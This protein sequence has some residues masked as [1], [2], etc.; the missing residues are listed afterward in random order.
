M[1]L[2]RVRIHPVKSFAGFDV[3][4]ATV[5][6]WGL[7]GDRRWAVVD[8]EGVSVTAR[9][10]NALLGL[11]ATP[12]AGDA[13]RLGEEHDT[14]GSLLVAAPRGAD[15][16][17]VGHSRQGT[18]LPAGDAADAWIS[19]RIGRPLRLVWQPDPTARTV[20]PD[21]GGRPGDSLTLADASPL[22]LASEASLRLLNELAAGDAAERG[23]A[24]PAPLVMERFR[25]NLVV[26]GET[27]FAEEAWTRVRIGDVEFRVEGCCDRCVMTTIDPETLVRGKEPIR[28]LARHRRREGKTW[29]G[30]RL[31]P[32]LDA[33]A[34]DSVAVG[35]ALHVLG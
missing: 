16:V 13:L 10:E 32:V 31:V 20:K 27:P 9:E 12:L 26:D 18:A 15:P 17:A 21:Y 4:S 1:Q 19:A 3:P 11:V 33:S 28:T 8:P 25:P 7:A 6:P 22:L 5:L 34:G 35:D 23:D 14:A 29:F 2:T 30:V 24:A